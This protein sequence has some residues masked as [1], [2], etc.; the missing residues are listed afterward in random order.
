MTGHFRKIAWTRGSIPMPCACEINAPE[1][2]GSMAQTTVCAGQNQDGKIR[3]IWPEKLIGKT[4]LQNSY[5]EMSFVR[6]LIPI[7]LRQFF[8][9]SRR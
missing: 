5:S 7:Y 8:S 6:N 1:L 9:G 4:E 2:E 3:L